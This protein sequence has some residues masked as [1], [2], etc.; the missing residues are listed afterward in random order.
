VATRAH[1]GARPTGV[2]NVALATTA[3]PTARP[4][5]LLHTWAI[6]NIVA[7]IRA[8]GQSARSGAAVMIAG[9]SAAVKHAQPG[10]QVRSVAMHAQE[11]RA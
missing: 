9:H 10:V 3:R 4:C 7:A 2:A 6:E 1:V 5:L 8:A 11:S